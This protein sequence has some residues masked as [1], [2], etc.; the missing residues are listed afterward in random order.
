MIANR[1]AGI[2]NAAAAGVSIAMAFAVGYFS[3]I[4]EG[5]KSQLEIRA[6]PVLIASRAKV[7]RPL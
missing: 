5:R 4:A 3:R 2:Q 6:D 7:T 1:A